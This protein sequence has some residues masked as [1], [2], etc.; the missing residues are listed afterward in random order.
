MTYVPYA[1]C[2]KNTAIIFSLSWCMNV[3]GKIF[4]FTLIDRI[5]LRSHDVS[6]HY[7]FFRNVLSNIFKK[8]S[9]TFKL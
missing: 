6:H 3:G 5:I 1:Y 7:T 9:D 4:G 8:P 2:I